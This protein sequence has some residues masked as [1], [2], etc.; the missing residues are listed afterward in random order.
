MGQRKRSTM[1]WQQQNDVEFCLEESA[2][3]TQDDSSNCNNCQIFIETISL[4]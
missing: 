2:W 4:C 3:R 1:V